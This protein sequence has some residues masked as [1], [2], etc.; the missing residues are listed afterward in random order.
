MG[1]YGYTSSCGWWWSLP[2]DKNYLGV[3]CTG[4]CGCPRGSDA[5]SFLEFAPWCWKD[6]KGAHCEGGYWDRVQNWVG[7]STWLCRNNRRRITNST[8]A[9]RTL[10]ENDRLKERLHVL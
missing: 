1:E 4:L 10:V 9:S 7:G 8:D 3:Q 5:P 6:V 2:E